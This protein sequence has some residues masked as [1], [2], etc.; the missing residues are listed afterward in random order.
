[1]LALG[2]SRM[3]ALG[4]SRML[5]LGASRMLALGASVPLA[6]RPQAERGLAARSGHKA[7]ITGEH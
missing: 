1:M 6:T 2:A 7:A 4:A 5:A 3:L